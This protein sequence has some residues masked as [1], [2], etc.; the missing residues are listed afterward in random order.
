MLSFFRRASRTFVSFRCFSSESEKFRASRLDLSNC[1]V[2]FVLGGP[3][4]GK[5]TQCD[6]IARDYGM[7]HLSAGQL[8]RREIENPQSQFSSLLDQ[9]IRE[10][11]IVPAEI[12]TELLQQEMSRISSSPSSSSS[13]CASGGCGSGSCSSPSSPSTSST[14]STSSASAPTTTASSSSSSSSSC[15]NSGGSCSNSACTNS[16][17]GACGSRAKNS[18]RLGGLLGKHR[19]LIDGFPRNFDNYDVWRRTVNA[20]LDCVLFYDAGEKV[21][22]QRLL[23]R[24]AGGSSRSDDN[25]TSIRKRF[26]TYVMETLPIVE[27]FRSINKLQVVDA[28]GDAEQVYALTREALLPLDV[29]QLRQTLYQLLTAQQQRDWETVQA[30]SDPALT[31]FVPQAKGHLVS[32][33]DFHQQQNQVAAASGVSPLGYSLVS[34]QLRVVADIGVANYV[35]LNTLSDGSIQQIAETRVFQRKNGIWVQIHLHRSA[36]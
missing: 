19:F 36:P 18:T 16:S 20:S 21:L 34:P 22:E 5:G 25:L 7:T 11:R 15:S 6:K 4:V 24:A 13:S 23:S 30:L 10:G 35:L 28:R 1:S 17:A 33:L 32:G 12:T 9:T 29:Q 2:V 8:L 31:A 26:H 3:G 27:F 14:S